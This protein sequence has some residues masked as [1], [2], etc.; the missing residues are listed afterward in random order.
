[1]PTRSV[2]AVQR[3]EDDVC[4]AYGRDRGDTNIESRTMNLEKLLKWTWIEYFYIFDQN[5][6]MIK[7]LLTS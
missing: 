5:G 6:N 3:G 2:I 1:M 4:V 7:K